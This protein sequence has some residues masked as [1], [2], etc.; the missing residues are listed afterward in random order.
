M[1]AISRIN[2]G[3]FQNCPG[4]PDLGGDTCPRIVFVT[5]FDDLLPE[6]RLAPRLV[7]PVARFSTLVERLFSTPF[8]GGIAGL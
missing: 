1:L 5:L 3:N 7:R 2:R 8:V 4:E 6:R